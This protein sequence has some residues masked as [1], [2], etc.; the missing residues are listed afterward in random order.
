MRALHANTACGKHHR[1]ITL[2]LPLAEIKLFPHPAILAFILARRTVSARLFATLR[3][4]NKQGSA[5]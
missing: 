2:E 3:G 1:H 4:V 5:Q